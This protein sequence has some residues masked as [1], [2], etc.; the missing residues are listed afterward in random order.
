MQKISMTQF[1]SIWKL[2]VKRLV[3][4]KIY[5]T[6]TEFRSKKYPSPDVIKNGCEGKTYMENRKQFFYQMVPT[7][8]S[9]R[10]WRLCDHC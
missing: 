2:Q 3:C 6:K 9:E 5:L 4:S 7:T 10:K 1:A 8:T